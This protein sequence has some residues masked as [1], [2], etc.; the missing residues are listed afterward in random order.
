MRDGIVLSEKYGV[1]PTIP[2]CFFCGEPKNELILMGKLKGDVEAPKNICINKEPC[3][4]CKEYMEKGVMLVSVK[5]NTDRENPY[6]TG[7]IA[8]ITVEAAEKIF[9]IKGRFAFIEDSAWLKVGLP[10]SK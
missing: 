6:R 1:N 7:N 10:V 3:D 9:G 2:I 4:Q 5:D 8:V